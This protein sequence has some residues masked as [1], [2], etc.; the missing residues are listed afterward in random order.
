MRIFRG[1][2]EGRPAYHQGDGAAAPGRGGWT[3]VPLYHIFGSEPLSAL[4]PGIA[5]LAPRPYAAMNRKSAEEIGAS[6]GRAVL[7]RAGAEYSLP[8]AIRD[9]MPDHTIGL[10]IGLPGVGGLPFGTEVSV[11]AEGQK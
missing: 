10:P 2:P 11:S 4:G 5:S 1:H 6:E 9:E 3:L 8:L 7:I